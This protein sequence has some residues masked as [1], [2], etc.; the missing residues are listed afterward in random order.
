[1]T[2]HEQLSDLYELFFLAEKFKLSELRNRTM[3][4]IQDTTRELNLIPNHIHLK[5]VYARTPTG[6]G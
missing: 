1:V 4:A 5:I 3:D 6:S 2:T